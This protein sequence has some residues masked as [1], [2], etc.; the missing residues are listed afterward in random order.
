MPASGTT[1]RVRVLQKP[2][3]ITELV[4]V[5]EAVLAANDP[6]ASAC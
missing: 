4:E 6:D 2:F 3:E 1:E 5:L